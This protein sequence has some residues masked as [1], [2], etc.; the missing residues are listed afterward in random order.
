MD[1]SKLARL[2]WPIGIAVAVLAGAAYV[3]NQ[4]NRETLPA[5]F[6]TGNGRIEAAEVDVATKFAGRV[7]SV[8]VMEGDFVEAGQVI[9]R[10][11]TTT[12]EAQLREAEAQRSQAVSARISAAAVVAQRESAKATA[13]AVVAQRQADLAFA[14]KQLQ[15]TRQLVDKKFISAQQLDVDESK[16]QTATSQLA[17]AKSG[18]AEA[19]AAIA[20][21]K[22]QVVEAQSGIEAAA[23]TIERIKAD[24]ADAQLKAPRSGRVQH[25]LARSGE[26]L[27]AGGKVIT[28]LDLSDVYMRVYLPETVAGRLAIG[29]EARLILDAAP[30]IVI[31]ATVSFVSAQA[32][33]TPKTVETASERQKLVFQVKLQIDPALLKKYETRVKAGLPGVAFVRVD[34]ATAWPE[35]LKINLP[36]APPAPG[37]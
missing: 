7:Q 33:F 35:N 34:A 31:P 6:A 5:A 2:A 29:G 10:M 11:D 26:V 27:P 4:M 18:V 22:S 30:D 23:A 36:A 25:L 32:Q 9:A 21:A 28:L 14:S 24:M 37:R 16:R 12:L 17:A 19:E 13:L 20:A 8:S 15:R 1:K 3:W